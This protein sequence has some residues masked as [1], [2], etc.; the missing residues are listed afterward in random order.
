MLAI[1]AEMGDPFRKGLLRAAGVDS[2]SLDLAQKLGG[3]RPTVLRVIVEFTAVLTDLNLRA[4]NIGNDGAI[5]IAGALSSGMAIRG[6]ADHHRVRIPS[7]KTRT[8]P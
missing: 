8:T 5:A 1:G 3:D 6:D 2:D 4:N 7:P